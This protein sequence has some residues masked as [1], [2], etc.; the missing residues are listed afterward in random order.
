MVKIATFAKPEIVRPHLQTTM[1]ENF[2]FYAAIVLT[3]A[4]TLRYLHKSTSKSISTDDKG[5]FSI[6]MH[7]L[8]NIVGII[9]IVLCL[10]ITIGPILAGESDI[11]IYIMTFF[12]FL[13]F[14]GL[15]LLCI[16]YYRNH[17]VLFDTTSITVQSPFG[18]LKSTSWQKL[19]KASFNP[20]SGMLILTDSDGQ[21]LK[22]HQHLVGL[23]KF[24]RMLE[25][26]T[27]WTS[28]ELKLPVKRSNVA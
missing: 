28:K 23:N 1:T 24:I 20:T 2:I 25:I 14:G 17:N 5:Q 16:L 13:L 7:K 11:G 6:R 12:M 10:V 18:K 3:V 26:K 9:S 4:L 19:A 15:G 21:K 8:Y 27:G 22:I